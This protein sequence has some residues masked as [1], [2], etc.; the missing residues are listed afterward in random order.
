MGK[1]NKEDLDTARAAALKLALEGNL[2][3]AADIKKVID[4]VEKGQAEDDERSSRGHH[5]T[6]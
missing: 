2:G 6:E 4:A 5:P 1:V 3:A